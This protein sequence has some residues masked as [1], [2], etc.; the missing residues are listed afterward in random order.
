MKIT[1]TITLPH[2]N[3]LIN[4]N[5]GHGNRYAIA[6]AKKEARLLAKVG[7]FG[8]ISKIMPEEQLKFS[9]LDSYA[10]TWYY[11][12]VKPDDDNCLSRIKAYKD[13]ACDALGINDR[14]LSCR[15]IYLVHC[16]HRAGFLEL[17]F[18]TEGKP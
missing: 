18:W 15:G 10:L 2:T 16:M 3:K 9:D 4:P 12:G 14:D 7:T 17:S 13:G 6:K 5:G 1:I 11:K 8:A